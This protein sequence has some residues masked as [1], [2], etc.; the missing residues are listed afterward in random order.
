MAMVAMNIVSAGGVFGVK[1][2]VKN[3]SAGGR[4]CTLQ[5]DPYFWVPT[6]KVRPPDGTWEDEK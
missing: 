3:M 2:S 5:E 4:L 6:I 1:L